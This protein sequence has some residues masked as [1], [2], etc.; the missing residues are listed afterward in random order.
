MITNLEK[1]DILPARIRIASMLRKAI[2]AGEFEKGQELSLTEIASQVKVSRTPVREAFQILESEGLIELRMNK[3]A[4]VKE[5]N[6]DVIKDHYD[7][8]MLLEG[9]AIHRAT[10]NIMDISEVKK[11]HAEILAIGGSI[12][13]DIYRIYNQNFHTSIWKAAK[14]EKLYSFLSNLWNG[15]S[16]GKTVPELEHQLESIKEHGNM[17]EYIKQREPDLAKS[18]M[19]LHIQRS[20]NNI[21][22]SFNADNY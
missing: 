18:Q 22:D 4:I 9:E 5:I 17:I 11:S 14:S 2:L 16:F 3:S 12:T 21:L 20:M 19:Q 13:S 1:I 15:C 6:V 7:M 10:I 8:R